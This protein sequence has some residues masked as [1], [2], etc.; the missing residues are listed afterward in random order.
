[1]RD[2]LMDKE[3]N[4]Q[5]DGPD[6]QIYKGL[7][8]TT[9]VDLDALPALPPPP[10]RLSHLSSLKDLRRLK[11]KKAGNIKIIRKVA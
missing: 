9:L 7:D 3:N 8:R 1:M 6:G 5:A 2:K 4:R 11:D 10:H